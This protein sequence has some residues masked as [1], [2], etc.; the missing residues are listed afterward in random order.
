V[1]LLQLP[2]GDW[3]D[4]DY[5]VMVEAVEMQRCRFPRVTYANRVIIHLSS[6]D[7]RVIN[8]ESFDD[9]I[10]LRDRIADVANGKRADL[11]EAL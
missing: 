3:I 10:N 7:R 5:I 11:S 1:R 6:D 9:A 8:C 2:S 4:P